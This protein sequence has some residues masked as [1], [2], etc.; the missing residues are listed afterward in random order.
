MK[1]NKTKIIIINIHKSYIYVFI[2]LIHN[3]ILVSFSDMIIFVYETV[4]TWRFYISLVLRYSFYSYHRCICLSVCKWR[5]YQRQKICRKGFHLRCSCRYNLFDYTCKLSSIRRKEKNMPLVLFVIYLF[6]WW[7][8]LW[9]LIL[10]VSCLHIMLMR[11]NQANENDTKINYNLFLFQYECVRAFNLL[12]M[13][14][15]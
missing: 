4:S 11:S 1:T 7:S 5:Y 12:R 6:L 14:C 13:W 2:L 8:W 9:L 10:S 15:F 3:Y